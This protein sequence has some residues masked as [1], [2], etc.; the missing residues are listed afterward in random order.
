[1]SITI[2]QIKLLREKTGVSMQACKKALEE[3][4]GD[5]GKAV[6]ILR[7][8]GEMKAVERGARATGEGSVVSYVHT[9]GKIGVLLQLSCETDF[10]ARS[11][12]FQ[13]LGKDIAM[14]IAA[15][16]PLFLQPEE[17]P[18]DLVNSEREIWKAQL[19][20]E[21]KPQQVVSKILEGKEK[22]FREE[23]A[24]YKQP[25][26]KNPDMSVEKLIS[27]AILK[28]GENLKITRFTRYSF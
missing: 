26:V 7:K 3:S 12:D 9:N 10:V 18:Q 4:N 2:E 21:G 23:V 20:K 16:N 25:F 13:N 5:E 15:M 22:K 1:M 8:K 24:L 14:H 6:E 11:Q 17:V 27:D 28:V 19:A